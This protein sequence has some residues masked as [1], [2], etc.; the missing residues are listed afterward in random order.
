MEFAPHEPVTPTPYEKSLQWIL[1]LHFPFRL[2]DDQRTL[3]M[4][5]GGNLGSYSVY[6]A[7]GDTE[8]MQRFSGFQLPAESDGEELLIP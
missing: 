7:P 8:A 1:D 3:F 2:A 5:S 4:H 6:S